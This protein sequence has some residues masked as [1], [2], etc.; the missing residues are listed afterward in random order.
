M[1]NI[2]NKSEFGFSSFSLFGYILKKLK[3]LTF[4]AIA[5][6]ILS[7]ATSF[8]ITPTY[9][10]KVVLFPAASTPISQVLNTNFPTNK[11]IEG[12]GEEEEAEQVLQILNSDVI[13][14]KMI[15]KFD[16]LN[17]YKIKAESKTKKSSLYK[18]FESN[19]SFRRTEF[20]SIEIS[21]LD[22]DPQIA[23]NMANAISDLIDTVMNSIRKDRVKQ[24]F[25]IVET[26][27]NAYQLKVKL[28]EDSITILRKSGI[29]HYE[30]IVDRL[31]EG[32]SKAL[33]NNN[34]NAAEK[35]ENRLKALSPFATE[36]ISLRDRIEFEYGQYG[37]LTL[38]R[39]RYLAMKVEVE[40]MLPT[41]YVVDRAYPADKKSYPIRS[42]IV[43]LSIISAV[44]LGIVASLIFDNW[45]DLK[46]QIA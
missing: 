6:A 13:K 41:K 40:Q 2:E 22:K 3:F 10:S 12:F 33:I 32:Y 1:N 25:K 4:I 29:N 11:N 43:I 21:I 39:S 26:E 46:S 18:E 34:L 7:A 14:D 35:L 8:L 38:L 23:A 27:Y 17:H 42:L 31:T 44:V 20:N 36:Y 9:K 45:E 15:S 16:L 37:Q 19:A 28:M 30:S 5:A 24:A